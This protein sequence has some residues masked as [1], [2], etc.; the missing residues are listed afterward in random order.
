M[1]QVLR[2]IRVMATSMADIPAALRSAYANAANQIR[3]HKGGIG[4]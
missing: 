1:D 4:P 3:W 2:L